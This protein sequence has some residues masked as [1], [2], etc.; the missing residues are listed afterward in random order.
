M[1]ATNHPICVGK[2]LYQ[3]QIWEVFERETHDGE[4]GREEEKVMC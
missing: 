4:D 2:R 3:G 1:K